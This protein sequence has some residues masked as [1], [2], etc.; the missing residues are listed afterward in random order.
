MSESRVSFSVNG[1]NVEMDI[2]PS[3]FLVDVLREDLR[4]TGT[5]E[6]C[7]IGVCGLCT[8]L[9]DGEPA[10]A[11]LMLAVLADGRSIT[12]I[13]G[14]SENGE[15]TAVQEAF[16]RHGGFQCGICTPG[17]IIGATALLGDNPRPSETEIREA[18]AGS[19]CRCTGYQGIVDAVVAAS[20]TS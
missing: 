7:S 20:I 9:V 4:L 11:C 5:K 16:I 1:D 6:G 8:V 19:L 13:E 2:D 18:M 15:L 3:R 12:T 10:T 17:Q 14:L